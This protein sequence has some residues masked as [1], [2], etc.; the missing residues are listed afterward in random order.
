LTKSRDYIK[1]ADLF[2]PEQV[3]FDEPL[4][5]YTTFGIGG[6]ADLLI[7][8]FHRDDLIRAIKNVRHLNIPFIM[9]GGGSNVLISDRGF[10]GLV[11][12][13]RTSE[14]SFD[15][16]RHGSN[17]VTSP[18]NMHL[19]NTIFRDYQKDC[20]ERDLSLV[21]VDTGVSLQHLIIKSLE[22]NLLGLEYF[23]GIPGTVG[24]ALYNNAHFMGKQI[25]ERIIAVEYINSGCRPVI[26]TP[27]D[28]HFGYDYTDFRKHSDWVA[29]RIYFALTIGDGEQ[30]LRKYR[31]LL[32]KRR[33]YPGRSAGCIFAN[34]STYQQRKAHLPSPS[35]GYINDKILGIR[36]LERGGAVLGKYHGNFITNEGNASSEDV[37]YLIRSIRQK[38]RER[39]GIRLRLE[40]KVII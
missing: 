38:Y 2:K 34:L 31:E 14:I 40:I 35:I 37:L 5:K 32:S 7:K 20:S 36:G 8:V 6:P 28:L 39:F 3:F 4:K 9:L 18:S 27:Q 25:G 13:N 12:L 24:G 19:L 29:T 11:I 15:N 26:A 23:A 16:Q 10:R 30:G 33:K 21:Q 22:H 17:P 1:L